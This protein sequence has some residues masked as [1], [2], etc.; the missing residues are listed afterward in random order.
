MA[1]RIALILAAILGVYLVFAAS[2]GIDLLKSDDPA[3]KGLG[4]AVLILPLIGTILV[5]REIKFGKLSYEMGQ[6]ISE[7]FLPITELDDAARKIFLESAI[8][9]TKNDME[10]WQ[11]W[12][13]VALGYDL[14]HER[15]LARDAMQYS[16]ELYQAAKPK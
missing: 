5:Y 6:Q 16:V 11:A 12:Y 14:L 9:K 2:R 10:N 7:T 13:S 8:E 4:V 1:R 15:R 3:V